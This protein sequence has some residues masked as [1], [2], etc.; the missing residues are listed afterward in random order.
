M[1][2]DP[3]LLPRDAIITKGR[4]T[5]H[6]SMAEGW[7]F[8]MAYPFKVPVVMNVDDAADIFPE[9]D[10]DYLGRICAEAMRKLAVSMDEGTAMHN[11]EEMYHQYREEH[12]K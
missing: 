5:V 11:V 3:V 8:S 1:T 7:E 6:V 4:L 2:E 9:V 10:Y 12:R